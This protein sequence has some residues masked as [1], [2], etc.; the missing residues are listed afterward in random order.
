MEPSLSSLRSQTAMI[1]ALSRAGHLDRAKDLF[2]R[3]PEHDLVSWNA[4]LAAF[5][6]HGHLRDAQDLFQAMRERNLISCDTSFSCVLAAC[7][8][9]G[10]FSRARACF[11]SM[12]VDYAL[13]PTRQHHCCVIDALGRA[14]YVA[15]ARDLLESMP[16]VPDP[17]DWRCLAGAIAII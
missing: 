9:V 17:L 2:D 8:R 1:T 4:M 14:K 13:Q 16:F 12:S 15:S 10:D 7:S 6:E 3:M 5:A 11:R